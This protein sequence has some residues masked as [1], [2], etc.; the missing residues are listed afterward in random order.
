MTNRDESEQNRPGRQ[1]DPAATWSTYHFLAAD[2]TRVSSQSQTASLPTGNG[3]CQVYAPGDVVDNTYRL[4]SLIGSGGMGVVFHCQHVILGKEYALKLLSSDNLTVESWSRFQSEAKALARLHH[5][6]VVGIHNMGIDKN[7]CPYYVMDLLSGSSLA[8]FVRK[9][10]RISVKRALN[11]FIQLAEALDAAHQQGIIHRDIKPS[12]IMV[13]EGSAGE[14]AKVV[15]FGIARLSNRGLDRQFETIAGSVFGTPFYMSPE[16]GLGRTVDE[17][18]DIYSLGCA[19][20]EALTGVPPLCGESAMET[21]MLHQTEP[22]PGLSEVY[23]KGDFDPGLEAAVAKMLAKDPQERYQSMKQVAHDLRRIQEGK[24]VGSLRTVPPAADAYEKA[25]GQNFREKLIP[26]LQARD[27]EPPPKARFSFSPAV[28]TAG[29]ALAVGMGIVCFWVFAQGRIGGTT[30]AVAAAGAP[31]EASED[32][33]DRGASD[34]LFPE[35]PEFLRKV[36][37]MSTDI[38]R[39]GV[40]VSRQFEFPSFDCKFGYLQAG[41]AQP[42]KAIGKIDVPPDQPVT[43]YM[44]CLCTPFPTICKKFGDDALTGLEIVTF[45]VPTVVKKI[46]GWTRLRHLSFFNS[47]ERVE[48]M[49]CSTVYPE[50]I[51]VIDQLTNLRSL[52]LCGETVSEHY[53]NG[54][55]LKGSDIT[56]MRLLS[57]LDTLMLKEIADI[58]PVLTAIWLHPNIKT[59]YLDNLDI[60]DLDIEI[61]SKST[62]LENITIFQCKK[63]TPQAVASFSKMKNL[64]SLHMDDNWSPEVRA[65]F[66]SKVKGYQYESYKK[67]TH[68]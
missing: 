26:A 45:E 12:N 47:I 17:R 15:D 21:V 22:A 62:G 8:Q 29:A 23:T 35:F 61:L 38:V 44:Q 36:P 5:S 31:T 58:R 13:V 54:L 19:F 42:R 41:S 1:P 51:P 66:A 6:G 67:N 28:I 34:P 64:K 20:F 59:L 52:G 18:S 40:V 49:D 33:W 60:D 50:D 30:A 4:L 3:R 56:G 48:G 55:Q 63:V 11:I 14:S 65:A 53:R 16:Q 9:E 57:R 25:I 68:H 37:K 10:R 2:P 24:A 46:T 7:Q 39:G 32:A 27:V 43:V